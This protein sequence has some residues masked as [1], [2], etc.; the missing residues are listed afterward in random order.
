MVH[1]D[2]R[3]FKLPDG[4]KDAVTAACEKAFIF[5]F[6]SYRISNQQKLWQ[7]E[8]INMPFHAF[9]SCGLW[10]EYKYHWRRVGIIRKP[11]TPALRWDWREGV[12][13]CQNLCTPSE[14]T[15]VSLLRKQAHCACKRAGWSALQGLHL[16]LQG[17][18]HHRYWISCTVTLGILSDWQL[19]F[20]HSEADALKK[21]KEKK[22][23]IYQ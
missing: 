16:Q 18:G 21:K 19:R 4:L 1:L 6:S 17:C 9:K 20:H 23:A 12:R 10:K 5:S 15:W 2:W 14:G 7:K 22:K 8:Q 11:L 13:G 3:V